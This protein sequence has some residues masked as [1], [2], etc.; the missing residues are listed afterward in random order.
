MR[1]S[2]GPARQAFS[3]L[4]TGSHT[5]VFVP[6]LTLGSFWLG[7]E[8]ALVGVSLLLPVFF[9]AASC[10]SERPNEKRTRQNNLSGPASHE[11]V[12]QT[13]ETAFSAA[14]RTGRTPACLIVELD[15]FDVLRKRYGL[16][17]SEDILCQADNRVRTVLRDRDVIAQ[18]EKA[19][20]VIALA[21]VQRADLE[22]LLQI[23]GRIQS[24]IAE[25]LLIDAATIY[26]SASI[27]FCIAGDAPE[28]TGESLLEAA[29]DALAEARLNANGAIRAY[30]HE[31]RNK[32]RFRNVMSDDVESALE[33]GQIQ[34]W[35]QPQLST[36]TGRITGFEALA[37]WCHPERGV[38]S[39]TD[40]LPAIENSGLSERLNEVMLFHALT[41]LKSWDDAEFNIPSV[42]VNFSSQELRNPKFVDKIKWELDRFDLAPERLSVEILETVVAGPGD[43]TVTR[44]LTTLANLGC[45][46]DLDDFGTGHAS[47]SNIRRFAVGRIKIDRSF[48]T[49]VDKDQSQQRMVSAILSLAERLELETLAEGVETIGEHAMLSQLGCSHVQ[50]FAVARPMSFEDSLPWIERQLAIL[51]A[52]P[53]FGRYIG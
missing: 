6:A 41:A 24:A 31:M 10:F 36:D 9:A 45:G 37:R 34:A 49:H 38:I 2:F 7:G 20:F 53:R 16:R 22:A 52:P 12:C 4:F 13:L 28:R 1:I 48:I 29:D 8:A 17:A 43:D 44:N 51:S 46:I 27:G 39:P 30:S 11:D 47:I 26:L 35:F 50:G 18:M 19:R 40:F 21:P 5:Y 3:D 32:A 33:N 23:S 25:P 42:A 14:P 15:D